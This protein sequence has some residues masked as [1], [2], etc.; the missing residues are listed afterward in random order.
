MRQPPRYEL[1][2]LE[3]DPFEFRNLAEAPG[4]AEIFH[5]LQSSLSAWR[6]QTEDPL[7]NPDHLR[8]LSEEVRSIKSKSTAKNHDWGYPDYFFGREPVASESPGKNRG[9]AKNASS[10]GESL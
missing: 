7:L 9:K 2:D 4:Y 1:Y 6:K 5:E 10:L 3:N 8:R